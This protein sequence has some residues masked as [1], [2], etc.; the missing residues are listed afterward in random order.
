MSK[1]R[2][3]CH[4]QQRLEETF[5]SVARGVQCRVELYDDGDV[6]RAVCYGRELGLLIGKHGQTIDAIQYLV[7]AIALRSWP[8]DRKVIVVDAAGYRARRQAS[9]EAL[10]VRSAERAVRSGEAV[11]LDP[12][13]VPNGQEERT[14]PAEPTGDEP[15]V[16]KRHFTIPSAYTILFFLIILSLL[17][18]ALGIT[19]LVGAIA[20]GIVTWLNDRQTRDG[21]ESV[22]RLGRER[23]I[24]T[25]RM[26]RTP[27]RT[28]R[29]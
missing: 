29:P 3:S 25:E 26:R 4:H 11:E 16:K 13:A 17:H 2:C 28:S 12:I 14:A 19:T 1:R 18:P 22:N 21:V 24:A 20:L 23:S 5:G 27:S 9:L 8:D 6:L 15:E 10:A 7:N